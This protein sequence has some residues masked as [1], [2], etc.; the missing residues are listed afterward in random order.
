MQKKKKKKLNRIFWSSLRFAIIL[1]VFL[2][3][4]DKI[5]ISISVILTTITNKNSIKLSPN[6]MEKES[7]I[8]QNRIE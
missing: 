8:N 4:S 7:V 1:L 3:M 5:T 2:Y 6:H